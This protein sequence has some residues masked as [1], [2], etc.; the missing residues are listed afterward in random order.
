[1]SVNKLLAFVTL[2]TL[3]GGCASNTGVIDAGKGQYVIEKQQATGFPGLGNLRAEVY[4]EAK[5]F[6]DDKG[7]EFSTTGY[8]ATKPPYILGNFPRVSL[9]FECV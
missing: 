4:S 2:A 5:L 3:V 7:R 6:C 1:M 9:T 8:E